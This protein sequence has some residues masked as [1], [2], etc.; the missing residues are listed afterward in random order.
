MNDTIKHTMLKKKLGA[1]KTIG[2]KL[3][4]DKSD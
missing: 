3:S 4:Q 1:L 2:A